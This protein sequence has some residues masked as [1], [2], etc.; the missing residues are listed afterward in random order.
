M[1]A[2]EDADLRR[3]TALAFL[4]EKFDVHPLRRHARRAQRDE[5]VAGPGRGGVDQAGHRLLA[6]SRWA[7]NQHAT[8]GA[9]QLGDHLSQL[10]SGH[11]L[12]EQTLRCDRLGP[13]ALVFALEIGG[14][15]RTLDHQQQSVR[16]EG[17]FQELVGAALDR[18]DSGLDVAVTGDHDHRHVHVERLDHV[19]ELET[20]HPAARHPDIEDRVSAGRRARMA[21]SADSE[22]VAVRTA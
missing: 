8:V 1:G 21:A 17:L 12:A 13:Q 16:L 2:F 18:T 4:A 9:G 10:L 6:G 15:Q 20:V 14:L 11:R 7:G 3:T 5:F 22:S 19:Q